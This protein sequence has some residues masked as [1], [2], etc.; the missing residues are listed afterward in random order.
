MNARV[1]KDK[2]EIENRDNSAALVPPA[3]MFE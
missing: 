1:R 2:A 3:L